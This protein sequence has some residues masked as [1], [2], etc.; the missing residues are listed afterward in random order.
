MDHLK[1]EKNKFYRIKR[2][3]TAAE[4][5]KALGRPVKECFA[6]A[7]IAA[8]NCYP[9]V[10]KPFESYASIAAAHNVDESALREFNFGRAL[11]PTRVIYIPV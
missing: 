1:L 7:I 10:V 2:G 8:A 6:G 5:E 11:Y 3:Q 4:A 9:Y